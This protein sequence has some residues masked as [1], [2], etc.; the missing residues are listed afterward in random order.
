M[1]YDIFKEEVFQESI[2]ELLKDTLN[3]L[4]KFEI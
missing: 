3:I 2:R 4:D 1:F